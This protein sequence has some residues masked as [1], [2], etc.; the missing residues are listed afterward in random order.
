MPRWLGR[1]RSCPAR[2]VLD[3]QV[4]LSEDTATAART[5]W[6]LPCI[7]RVTL[8]TSRSYRW[9]KP[10]ISG[11]RSSWTPFFAE[12]VRRRRAPSPGATDAHSRPPVFGPVTPGTG[13]CRISCRAGA[14]ATAQRGAKAR[15]P[16]R[17]RPGLQGRR[18]RILAGPAER[19]EGV[20]ARS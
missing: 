19:D 15:L 9:T 6:S 16:A 1:V 8:A 10:F 2:H 5:T 3:E 17:G 4:A 18:G 14:T 7:T 12:L 20:H 11:L 13:T